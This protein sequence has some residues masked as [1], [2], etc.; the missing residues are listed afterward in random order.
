MSLSASPADRTR[1]FLERVA[2][3]AESQWANID[4]EIT[5]ERWTPTAEIVAALLTTLLLRLDLFAPTIHLRVPGGRHRQLPRLSD[6]ALLDAL[7][8]EHDG[9][10]SIGRLTATPVSEPAIRFILGGSGSGG[11]SV[12]VDRWR[13]GLGA[14]TGRCEGV[15]AV[16][17]FAGVLAA[18]EVLQHM[19]S[20]YVRV[21]PF[22]ELVS[23]WDLRVGGDDGPE[24]DVV[25]LDAVAFAA[26]GGVASAAGWTLALHP[27]VGAPRLVDPD[28]IDD[29]ATNL[30]RHLTASFVDIGRPKA[31]LLAALLDASGTTSEVSVAHWTSNA[32]TGIEVVVAS[33][34]HDGV[35]RQVQLDLPRVVLAGG[36]GDNGTYQVAR[37]SFI[38]GA[39]ACCLWR[40]DLTDTS[41]LD[42]VARA[43]GVERPLL[44]PHVADSEPLPPEVILRIPDESIR[45]SIKSVPGCQ[46]VEHVCATIRLDP[47]APAVSAPM[48]AAAPGII[49]AVELIKERLGALTPLRTSAN[50]L[51]A[52]TLGG[53]HERWVL[54]RG[55][56][57]LC[58]CT[59]EFYV[60]HYRRKWPST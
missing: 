42:G 49:L 12:D 43:L 47:A 11:I 24:V 48:L 29:D 18:N 4:V 3:G 52:S 30:N 5:A 53:P 56:R 37:H 38:E 60:G 22:R 25:D 34:D 7:A 45:E 20:P 54:E 32:A 39:C 33:P 40:G 14:A 59:D 27:L 13:T 35:R 17:A 23:L 9:F 6:D 57:P 15:P 55:K 50:T 41:P 8:R 21:R 16:A 10:G 1:R 36:T 58:E 46:L 44:E 19:L 51:T 28:A 26:C 31:D 2:P